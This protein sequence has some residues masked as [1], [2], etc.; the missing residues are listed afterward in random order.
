MKAMTFFA[1]FPAFVTYRIHK[2]TNAFFI[3]WSLEYR[4]PPS[5]VRKFTKKGNAYMNSSKDFLSSQ[6]C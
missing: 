1:K 2:F 3:V 6:K 4:L 5:M